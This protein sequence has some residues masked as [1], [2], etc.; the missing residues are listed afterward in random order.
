[1]KLLLV[2]MAVLAMTVQSAN[3]RFEG[4]WSAHFDGRTFL[5][6]ELKS[7]NNMLTGGISIGDLEIDDSGALQQAGSAPRDLS[8]I[9]DVSLTDSVLRFARKDGDDVDRFEL[10][11]NKA[12]AAELQFVLSDDQ[13]GHFAA[14]GIP[15]PKPFLLSK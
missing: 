11:F 3:A 14:N 12:G 10:R 8:P 15:S 7:A 9:F 4:A 1:M 2:P 5:R 6:L 13:R